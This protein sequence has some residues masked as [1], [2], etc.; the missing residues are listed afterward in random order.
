MPLTGGGK[1][2][3]EDE[4]RL[5][6]RPRG[7]P[8]QGKADFFLATAPADV[9]EKMVARLLMYWFRQDGVEGHTWSQNRRMCLVM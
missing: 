3:V 9:L 2:E 5:A 4:R 7:R 1:H 8:P 6:A